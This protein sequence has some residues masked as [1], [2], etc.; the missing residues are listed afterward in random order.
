MAEFA[1]AQE[2]IKLVIDDYIADKVPREIEMEIHKKLIDYY[3]SNEKL[4]DCTYSEFRDIVIFSTNKINNESVNKS[5]I[6]A[7]KLL[8]LLKDRKVN[9]N[10][11]CSMSSRDWFLLL[12][13]NDICSIG[14]AKKLRIKIQSFDFSA[15]QLGM[16]IYLPFNHDIYH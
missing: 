10:R 5:S 1:E 14:K 3:W 6:D 13:N 9:G 11:F 4:S 7:Q 15:I 12:R 16:Q 2:E 8:Y